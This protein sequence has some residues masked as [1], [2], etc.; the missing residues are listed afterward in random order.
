[1]PVFSP[2]VVVDPGD[3][4]QSDTKLRNHLKNQLALFLAHFARPK[5]VMV[6]ES[7]NSPGLSPQRLKIK[8]E[9]FDEKRGNAA[10]LIKNF[11]FYFVRDPKSCASN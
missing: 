10:L 5:W 9:I 11:G 6:T 8:P 1:M 3:R 2:G 4:I 7:M